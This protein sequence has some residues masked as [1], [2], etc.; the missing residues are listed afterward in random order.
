MKGTVLLAHPSP[1]LYG[2]DRVFLE[3]ASGFRS[4]GYRV[5]VALPAH[6]PLA[7]ALSEREIVIELLPFPVLRKSYFTPSGMVKLAIDTVRSLPKMLSL[8]RRLRPEVL[9]INTVTIP[10]W[11]TASRLRRTPVVCH[12]HE[13]ELS[14]SRPMRKVLYAPLLFCSGLVVN[15]RF[16]QTVVA[17]TWSILRKRSHIVY[18]GVP[19]PEHVE[20]LRA[21]LESP[22][23]LIYVGRLSP[24]KGPQVAIEALDRLLKSGLEMRLSLLGSVFPGYEWFETE[25]RQRVRRAGLE[26][27]VDF[28]GFDPDIWQHLAASD[29]VLVPSTGEESFGN[30]AVEAILA[31][32]PLVVSATSGLLEAADGYDTARKVEPGDAAGLAKAVQDL[33]N[34]WD[35]VVDQIKTDRALA[36]DR[37]SPA[38][39][40][41]NMISAVVRLS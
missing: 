2:S 18:N 12:V 28:I 14:L 36:L 16:T 8:L 23:R 38:S 9:L 33:I 32:R 39:F 7:D 13:A 31:S 15:S 25:L 11:I 24:R 27:R 5:V 4:A 3:T 34:E 29:I 1:D 22:I 30:T 40:Q 37:H 10:V 6:G 35:S 21:R 41:Q 19:G 17:S 20:P 26:Q